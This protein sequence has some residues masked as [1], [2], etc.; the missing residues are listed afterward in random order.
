MNKYDLYFQN[1]M[2]AGLGPIDN[3]NDLKLLPLIYSIKRN[4]AAGYAEKKRPG[5]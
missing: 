2:D 1:A 5:R 4:D 3:I